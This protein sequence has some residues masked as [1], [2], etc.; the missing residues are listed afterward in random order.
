VEGRQLREIELGLAGNIDS[1]KRRGFV[2]RKKERSEG[3]NQR[4]TRH[5]SGD[6]WATK[7]LKGQRGLFKKNDDDITSKRKN[8]LS[9]RRN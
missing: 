5:F 2:N 8:V 4:V 9:R 6:S 1:G 7:T 3:R